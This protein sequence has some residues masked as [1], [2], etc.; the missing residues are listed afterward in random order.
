VSTAALLWRQIEYERKLLLRS[1]AALFF[2]ILLPIIFL[3]IF[4]GTGSDTK[5]VSEAGG[6]SVSAYYVPGIAVLGIVSTTFLNLAMSLTRRRE[7]GILKR[8]R[9]TPLPAGLYITG[10]VVSAVATSFALVAV[11]L[12]LG[13]A[14]YGIDVRGATL[15]GLVVVVAISSA[16]LCCLGIAFTAIIPSEDAAPAFANAVVLPLY[17]ISGVFFSTGDAP[18]WLNAIADVFPVRHLVQAML[19]VFN[20]HTAGPG[21]A[22]SHVAVIALWGAAGAVLAA[23]FFS[24]TPKRSG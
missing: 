19:H 22:W 21:I 11:L 8:M 2:S 10:R 7:D 24:W 23:R 13:W 16:A 9:G 6:I 14:L 17:F 18:G 3:V 20:P 15:P 4:A 1:P 5:T 12:F